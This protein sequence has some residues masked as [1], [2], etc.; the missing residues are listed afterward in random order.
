MLAVIIALVPAT[1]YGIY[2]FG[3]SALLLVL[4]SVA[5]AVLSEWGFRALI[6]QESHLGDCSAI[7]T[8]LLLALILPP[9]TPLWMAALGAIMAI[10]VAKEFFGGLGQN[11]FNPALIGRAF[12]L[13]SFPAAMTTWH[14]PL[15]GLV[16]AASTATPLNMVKQGAAM[17]DVAASVGA[18][19]IGGMYWQLFLGNRAGSLGETSILLVAIGGLF[20]IALG[21]IQFVI[22]LAMLGSTALFAW[23]L[24]MDPLFAILSGGVVFGAFFMATDYSTSPITL[25]G[26]IVYGIGIG[27]IVVL[28]RKLGGFPEG[29]TYAILVMNMLS[30]YLDKLRGR[31]YGRVRLNRSGATAESTSASSSKQSGIKAESTSV[32]SSEPAG[33]SPLVKGAEK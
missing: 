14:K 19:D 30:P 18:S 23:L 4:V 7:V 16:D 26:Q 31:K 28:I 21:V 10:V 33:V 27:L 24:G 5:S 25:K 6:K 13:M 17:K 3:V 2:L 12:L 32:S 11:P 1:V 20:L 9:S 15:Q 29:V 22:P 8:G